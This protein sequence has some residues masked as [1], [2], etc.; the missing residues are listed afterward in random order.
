MKPG[1]RLETGP[2]FGGPTDRQSEISNRKSEG[3]PTFRADA[4]RSGSVDTRL[5]VDAKPL[6]RAELGDRV[7]PPISVGDRVFVPLADEHQVVAVDAADGSELWRFH[8]GARIDSPPTYD[9]GAVLFGSA[10]GWVYRV[11]ATDGRL[12]WRFRAAPEDRRIAA[13]GQLESAWPVHGSVLVHGGGTEGGAGPVAYFAAGRSSHLDGGLCLFAIDAGTGR[14]VH[15]T[16]LTGPVYT[17]DNIQQNYRLPMGL[18]PDVLRVE[19]S[20]LFMRAVKFNTQ[21]ERQPGVPVLKIRGGLLDDAYFKRMPWSMGRS[22]HARLIVHDGVSAYCL[23]MFDSLQG[24]D[25]KVYFTPG[26]EGYLLFA[27]DLQ[28]G[29]NTWAHRIPIRGRAMV[30]TEDQLCVA[31]PPDVVDP[32]DPLGAFEGRKGG[33]LRIVD[34]VEGRTVSEHKL[35]APPVF[36]GAAAANGRLLLALEDGSV[37]CF[38]AATSAE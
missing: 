7:G 3:W 31:G 29:K 36:N 33:V 22:G 19:D 37:T 21:L 8:A 27:H 5:P 6:W 23:R 2:A 4:A 38:C 28:H 13:F 35:A 34:K 26:K 11:L 15:E 32:E 1:G 18:L 16:K 10:D 14:V 30:V 9:R 12:V 20:A 17:V 25:P 24:L